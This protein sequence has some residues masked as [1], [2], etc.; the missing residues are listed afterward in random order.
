MVWCSAVQCGAVRGVVW[1]GEVWF[2]VVQCGVVWWGWMGW[3]AA[4]WGAVLFG[5][6]CFYV[7]CFGAPWTISVHTV[8]RDSPK[9]CYTIVPCA[10]LSY[11]M[12]YDA[13]CQ[14]SCDAP[15]W[16]APSQNVSCP[17][18]KVSRL[19]PFVTKLEPTAAYGAF[20]SRVQQFTSLLAK[21]MLR[22]TVYSKKQVD[23]SVKFPYFSNIHCFSREATAMHYTT[24]LC[25]Y[26]Y[27]CL[28]R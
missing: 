24:P 25:W 5:M 7:T 16:G 3:G 4:R 10:A 14:S 17:G 19:P 8:A 27:S 13:L 1:F 15:G 22:T 28:T 21:R 2:G 20:D 12:C 23:S 18:R 9:M 26:R 6:G 11:T